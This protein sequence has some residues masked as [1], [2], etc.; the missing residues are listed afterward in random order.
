M[1]SADGS[2]GTGLLEVLRRV[3]GGRV[4]VDWMEVFSDGGKAFP[5]E[6]VPLLRELFAHGQVRLAERQCREPL[7][8]VMTAAGEE[9]LTELE[10]GSDDR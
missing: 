7:Y 5:R 2:H 1:R 3:R 9:L 10:A 6:L 4:T 8:V